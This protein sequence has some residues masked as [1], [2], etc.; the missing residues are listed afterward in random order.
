[1][2]RLSAV[3]ATATFELH[4]QPFSLPRFGF[5]HAND[6]KPA[7][8]KN[9]QGLLSWPLKQSNHLIPPKGFQGALETLMST[10]DLSRT[11]SMNRGWGLFPSQSDDLPLKGDTLSINQEP[12]NLGSTLQGG[13]SLHLVRAQRPQR[14]SRLGVSDSSLG[15]SSPTPAQPH[16]KPTPPQPHPNPT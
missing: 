6:M 13:K 12:I 9:S 2:N 16:P 14:V 4:G 11:R 8:T 10:P 3:F 15:L 7:S 1:M 5:G